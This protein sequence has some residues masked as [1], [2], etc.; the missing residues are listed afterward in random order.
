MNPLDQ[1][2]QTLRRRIADLLPDHAGHWAV[3][4]GDDVL[5]TTDSLDHAYEVAYANGGPDVCLVDAI[6]DPRARRVEV[7]PSLY[8]RPA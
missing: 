3:V 5:V 7:A 4:K 6:R 1:A 8:V 2:R